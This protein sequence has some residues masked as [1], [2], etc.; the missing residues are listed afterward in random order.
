MLKCF[1]ILLLLAGSAHADPIRFGLYESWGQSSPGYFNFFSSTL[2]NDFGPVGNQGTLNIGKNVALPQFDSLGE[3]PFLQPA[4][5]IHA[6][7]GYFSTP[8]TL[9]F[10]GVIVALMN[11]F[12]L[13]SAGQQPT[14]FIGIGRF[15]FNLKNLT[16]L[17]RDSV[18]ISN[19]ANTMHS[20]PEPATL[21]MISS[22][23]AALGMARKRRALLRT[24]GAHT[25]ATNS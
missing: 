7:S 21:M 3:W 25:T 17:R 13:S 24:E 5:S 2:V 14:V 6:L 11:D 18:W 1:L 19:G 12:Y 16:L 4:F 10:A 15:T 8:Y 22:G 20:V 23:L 9:H